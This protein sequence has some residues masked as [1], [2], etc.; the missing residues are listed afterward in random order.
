MIHDD[1]DPWEGLVLTIWVP[2]ACGPIIGAPTSEYSVFVNR[3]KS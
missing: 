1:S 2:H 3:S